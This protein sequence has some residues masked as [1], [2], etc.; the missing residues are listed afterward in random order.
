MYAAQNTDINMQ[1][2]A[3]LRQFIRLSLDMPLLPL[4]TVTGNVTDNPSFTCGSRTGPPPANA[5]SCYPRPPAL[6]AYFSITDNTQL[7]ID[8]NSL[9]AQHT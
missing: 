1:N 9:K 2:A 5:V 3:V 7:Q 8:W 6:P 4:P